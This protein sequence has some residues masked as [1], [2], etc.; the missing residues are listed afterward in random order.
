MLA[1]LAALAF[2]AP[3]ARQVAAPA[4]DIL[5][6]VVRLPE[7]SSTPTVSSVIVLPLRFE[8]V[9]G[10]GWVA[11]ASLP[12][13]RDGDLSL[14]LLSPDAGTWRLRGAPAGARHRIELV[15]DEMPG[16]V[17]DRADA[18][19]V[20]AGEWSLRVEADD[21]LG[22]R[23]PAEGW[24][25]AKPAGA[26]RLE[27]YVTTQ[28]LVAGE[29]IGITAR[30]L[31]A[32]PERGRVVLQS[33]GG[34][35]ELAMDRDASGD[36][37]F[38]ARLP[39]D[40]RGDVRARVELSGTTAEGRKF[41]R[42]AELTFPV[43]EPRLVLEPTARA[44]VADAEHVSLEIACLPLAP[45]QRLHVSAE[46]WGRS[47][48]GP[49]VPVCWLSRMLCPEMRDGTWTLPLALDLA[50]LDIVPCTA[51]FELRE[52]RVQDPDLEI[53]LDRAARMPLELPA[54]PGT[55]TR[56]R[57][58]TSEMLTG[59][60]RPPIAP[61]PTAPA[62]V[63][64]HGYCSGGAVWPPA[65]FTPPKFV[66][67]D[68]NANRT[69]DQFAQLIAQQAGAAGLTSFG[70]VAHSQGGCAALHLLTYYRS[71]LDAADGARRIQSVASPYQGTPLASLGA[72]ACG[73][74]NDMTP[75]GAAVWLAG[76]PSWA[77]AQVSYWTTSNSGSACSIFTD[78]FLT[79]PE[80]GVVEMFRGQLPG[81]NSMGHVTGWCHTTGMTNPANYTDHARN[82]AMDAAAAR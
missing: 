24:L 39:D 77:R 70:I 80:D 78:G 51:P 34:A 32:E 2:Q 37:S 10:T 79:N 30:I 59:S 1:L 38:T 20:L 26:L 81:G 71:G 46:L 31:G 68:P 62:L 42:T 72:F 35:R 28:R 17:V 73:V 23:P 45:P 66:F 47:A 55:G 75:A 27:T 43:V 53:V 57:H 61:R 3:I 50:W 44:H 63:L 36:G 67:L 22:A 19:D 58:I 5:A 76:I 40:V 74:N 65:D 64:V 54:L 56:D 12:V 29:P 14:M 48:S 16:W 6:G 41:L 7:P 18:R 8:R 69:H 60:P 52:V 21:P 15:G 25:I 33:A 4:S 49:M 82:Q 13:E 9:A 11:A